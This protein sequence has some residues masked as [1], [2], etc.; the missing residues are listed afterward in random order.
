M[1]KSSRFPGSGFV[2][3]SAFTPELALMGIIL[4][5]TVAT[6]RRR[7]LKISDCVRIE[8]AFRAT[9]S[10]MFAFQLEDG[11]IMVEIFPNCFNAIVA[12]LAVCSISEGMGR[13]VDFIH[14]LVAG[15]AG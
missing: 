2:A 9:Q 14:L 5:V 1:I 6:F 12:A 13:H 4:L 15:I 10:H 8:M 11:T 3:D 7:G